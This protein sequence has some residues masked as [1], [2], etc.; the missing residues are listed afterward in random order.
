MTPKERRFVEEYLIDLNAT[1]AAIRAGYAPSTARGAADW[2][3]EKD[4]EK[5]RLAAQVRAAMAARSARTGVTADRVVRELAQLAFADMAEVLDAGSGRIRDDA[6]MRAVNS[7]RI[8]DTEDGRD[9]EIRL[10]DKSRALELLGKHLGMFDDTL[11]V[12]LPKLPRIVANGDGS[13]EI[14]DQG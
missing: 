3:R 11:N 7:M 1:A 10:H 2:I 12:N 4:P 13:V 5:P 14:R 8:R 6:D 9:V